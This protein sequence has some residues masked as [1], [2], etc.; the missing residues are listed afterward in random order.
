VLDRRGLSIEYS[1]PAFGRALQG[2]FS[3]SPCSARAKPGFA[4]KLLAAPRAKFGVLR[5]AVAIL[6]FWYPSDDQGPRTSVVESIVFG[7]IVGLAVTAIVDVL[8]VVLG[9][10]NPSL[11][12]VV[13]GYVYFLPSFG[14]ITALIGAFGSAGLGDWLGQRIGMRAG[15]V[16]MFLVIALLSV[17]FLLM[18]MVAKS[19]C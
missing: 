19:P 4:Q 9:C 17:G 5:E 3:G 16:A 1:D 2:F 11:G 12:I 10:T 18:G 8:D 7:L 13:Y 15:R 14:S 6:R